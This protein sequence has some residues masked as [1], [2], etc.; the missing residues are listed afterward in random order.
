MTTVHDWIQE[1]HRVH[2]ATANGAWEFARI[3]H[4]P[5]GQSPHWCWEVRDADESQIVGEIREDEPDAKELAEFIV[6]AHEESPKAYGAVS[7]VLELHTSDG[8][9]YAACTECGRDF[10]CRTVRAITQVLEVKT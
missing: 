2:E 6:D 10:P 5:E 7:A 8:A 9:L 3:H 4:R 1:R